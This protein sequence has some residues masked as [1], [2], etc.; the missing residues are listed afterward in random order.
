M[1][2]AS[3]HAIYKKIDKSIVLFAADPLMLPPD[4]KR[5]VQP[6][7]VICPYIEQNRKTV[8]RMN[9]A[10]RGVKGHLSDWDAHASSALITKSKD[11]FAVADDDTFRIVIA[12]M[13]QNLVD[14]VL[15]RITEEQTAGLSPYLTETLAALSYGRR[16]HQ[17]EHL[18]DVA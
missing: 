8:L 6:V 12:R 7:L 3:L 13:V 5:A 11:A 15:V 2:P 14:A 10:Q 1:R 16:I 9:P 4:V 17:R 18:F